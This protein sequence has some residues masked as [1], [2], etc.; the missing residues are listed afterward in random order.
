AQ[1]LGNVIAQPDH[2]LF[3]IDSI[4]RQLGADV[5]ERRS[6]AENLMAVL[7]SVLA[8]A[9][10]MLTRLLI[11]A[12]RGVLAVRRGQQI[13]GLGHLGDDRLEPLLQIHLASLEQRPQL[14][15]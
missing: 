8:S 14:F 7:L 5:V 15:G 3:G 13:A 12:S 4:V 9:R 6:N 11:V 2:Q 1:W 10:N